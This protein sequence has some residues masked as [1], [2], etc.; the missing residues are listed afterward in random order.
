M[1]PCV[2]S[3]YGFWWLFPIIM[4]AMMVLC[5]FMMRGRMGTMICRPGLRGIKEDGVKNGTDRRD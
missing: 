2:C 3:G 1:F 5:F 4:I